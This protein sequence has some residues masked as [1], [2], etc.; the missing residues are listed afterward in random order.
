MSLRAPVVDAPIS[1]VALIRSAPERLRFASALRKHVVAQFVGDAAEIVAGPGGSPIDAVVLG[2]HNERSERLAPTALPIQ[3]RLPAAA[4]LFYLSLDHGEV[5]EALALA[6]RITPSAFILR[7]ID[8]V[9][10]AIAQ[11]VQTRQHLAAT[12]RIVAMVDRIA[13][14]PVRDVL[15]FMARNGNGPLSVYNVANYAGVSRR[16]LFNHFQR[17]G[18]PTFARVM[19]WLRLLQAAACLD[20]PNVTIEQIADG[21][22]FP[23]SATLRYLFKRFTGMT[24]S[25]LREAGGFSYLLRLAERALITE[26]SHACITGT[27]SVPPRDHADLNSPPRRF[28]AS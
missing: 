10:L 26:S 1:V 5:R 15:V 3:R 12:D 16:T 2:L 25:D 6:A 4:L 24:A 9:S 14:P 8:D 18:L 13:A 22:K 11:A 23:S 27:R 7:A 21:L 17:A 20:A 28:V 19:H